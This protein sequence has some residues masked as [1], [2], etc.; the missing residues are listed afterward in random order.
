MISCKQV[1]QYVG[2]DVHKKTIYGYIMD[3][4]GHLIFEKEFKTQPHELDMFLLN[5][6]R[7]D[8]IV[9]IESC[10]CWQYTYDYLH[11]AGYDLKLAHPLGIKALKKV[12]KHTDKYFKKR[13][14]LYLLQMGMVEVPKG[15]IS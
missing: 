6:K 4:Q 13:H 7:N 15:R 8:S 14:L 11:D 10:S 9:A 1:S 12:K 5:I 3:K 2:L